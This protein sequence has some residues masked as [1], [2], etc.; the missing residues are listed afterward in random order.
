MFIAERE[1][2]TNAFAV[3]IRDTVKSRFYNIVG[4]HQMKRK[5]EI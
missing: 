1:I 5:I 3:I 2:R 4:Q